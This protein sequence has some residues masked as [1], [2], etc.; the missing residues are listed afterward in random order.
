MA[1]F[2]WKFVEDYQPI[3]TG[4]FP[5]LVCWSPREG[6][7]ADAGYWDGNKFDTSLPITHLIP[8]NFPNKGAAMAY[9]EEKNPNW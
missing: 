1:N 6:Y 7:F 2:Q 4:W 3:S 8:R 5:V 9:A